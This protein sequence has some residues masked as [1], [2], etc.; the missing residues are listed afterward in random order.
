MPISC[1]FWDCN[2]L[3]NTS[4]TRVNSAISST[5]PLPLL[6]L[7]TLKFWSVTC[8]TTSVT[9]QHLLCFPW[10]LKNHQQALIRESWS[11]ERFVS[12]DCHHCWPDATASHWVPCAAAV[13]ALQAVTTRAATLHSAA[14]PDSLPSADEMQPLYTSASATLPVLPTSA[15]RSLT[16][17]SRSPLVGNCHIWHLHVH[18]AP[19]SLNDRQTEVTHKNGYVTQNE[20][21]LKF[22]N[23]YK[24]LCIFIHLC[25]ITLIGL[26]I[27]N[28]SNGLTIIIKQLIANN[29]K[30]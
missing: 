18:G 23:V 15:L 17:A 2:A 4:L 9:R 28:Y 13:S 1:H 11:H 5:K 12:T 8:A 10:T 24:H 30:E 3:L 21:E 20:N 29:S 22:T 19:S 14:S 25:S 26:I 16:L 6:L 27:I 7:Y